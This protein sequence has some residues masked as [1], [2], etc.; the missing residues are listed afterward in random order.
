METNQQFAARKRKFM[1]E[2]VEIIQGDVAKLERSREQKIRI[3]V[4]TH[5]AYIKHF[6]KHQAS[7]TA[8]ITK[9]KTC[10]FTRIHAGLYPSTSIEMFNYKS[11]V[12]LILKLI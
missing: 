12:Q 5:G 9:N 2:L 10:A 4:V 8:N 3:L 11:L 6:L 7:Y 1:F